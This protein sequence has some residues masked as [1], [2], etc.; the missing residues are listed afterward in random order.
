MSTAINDYGNKPNVGIFGET[1]VG[2]N[3]SDINL[4][5]SVEKNSTFDLAE[6][7]TG[8]GVISLND[9][10][11]IV[12][13]TTGTA[14]I[15]T[16]DVTRY[17]PGHTG[18]IQFT[19]SFEGNGIGKAGGLDSFYVK[20]A[21]G[22]SYFCYKHGANE[23]AYRI[24]NEIDGFNTNTLDWNSIN[25]FEIEYGYLGVA[26][27]SLYTYPVGR[28]R[29]LLARIDT[30][31]VIKG[32]HISDPKFPISFETSGAM[33]IKAASIAAGTYGNPFEPGIG[34]PFHFQSNGGALS[35]TVLKTL[36]NFYN[37]ITF[38]GLTNRKVARL[39]SFEFY[40]DIPASG[41]GT[42]EFRIFKNATLTGTPSYTA[43]SAN[44][45]IISVDTTAQYASGGFANITRWVSYVGANRGGSAAANVINAAQ[46]GLIARPGDIFTITAQNV[47]G[48]T[49]VNVRAAFNWE[50][51]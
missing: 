4:L 42:V 34:R 32:T 9:S 25:I 28:G 8:D 45:S 51:Y 2:Y 50:E 11:L 15:V 29:T 46:Y 38:L 49:A 24:P 27:P 31:G 41:T 16:R 10:L 19:A 1:V 30:Q 48:D 13:S 22:V 7:V 12:S 14:K 5:F 26:S 3:I 6:T 18:I 39:I 17:R 35:T 36:G 44:N 20:R 43:V 47:A 33:T 21:A 40:V 23:F 37:P